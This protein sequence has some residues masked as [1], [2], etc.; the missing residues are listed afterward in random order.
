MESLKWLAI[1]KVLSQAFR[2]FATIFTMRIL[3][4]EDYAIIALSSFFIEFLWMFSTG[5]ILTAIVREKNLPTNVL[6]QYTT[7]SYL[8]HTALFLFLYLIAGFIANL[9]GNASLEKVIQLSSIS[10]LIS[11][12]GLNSKALLSRDLNF[13]TISISEA[14][15][16]IFCSLTT[17]YLAY[18]GL[19]FWAIVWGNLLKVTVENTLLIFFKPV[20]FTPSLIKK[21][22]K[23]LVRFASKAAFLGALAHIATNAD[24][25]IAGFFLSEHELG[26]FQFAVVFAMMPM[27]KIMPMLRQVALPAYAKLQDDPVKLRQYFIKSQRMMLFIMIPLFW[28]I[29]SCSYTIIPIVFGDK[30]SD[31]CLVLSV[32]CLS[33]PLKLILELVGPVFKAIGDVN[34]L[35]TNT[36]INIAIM[37]PSFAIGSLWGPVGLAFSWLVGFSIVF[38]IISNRICVRLKI[39][40]KLFYF[41]IA[42]ILAS[43]MVML[44]SVLLATVLLESHI[45]IFLLLVCQI[46]VGAMAYLFSVWLFD[47]RILIEVSNFIPQKYRKWNL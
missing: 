32:Y 9:Y 5:G 38:I 12:L 43:G 11:C 47:K 25:A 23:P 26:I 45:N 2:W 39:A 36:F 22:T 24:I 4:P 18:I 15:G 6:K 10:F 42:F 8:A 33:I 20:F 30:W 31:A 28:G 27:S 37:L 44:I 29:S 35:I 34:T 13:K 1:G 19:G 16:D 14:A 21:D 46:M 3:F 7:F 40:L 41:S 17:L